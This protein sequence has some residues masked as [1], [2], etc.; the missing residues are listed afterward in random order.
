ML[1][2]FL[3][4]KKN[5]HSQQYM[6]STNS[7]MFN[8]NN[9][10][11]ISPYVLG[12]TGYGFL[13]MLRFWNWIHSVVRLFALFIQYYFCLFGAITNRDERTNKK[14][15]RERQMDIHLIGLDSSYCQYI[16]DV[17]RERTRVRKFPAEILNSKYSRRALYILVLY[18]YSNM[19]IGIQ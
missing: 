1:F 14:R 16:A 7:K 8:N 17:M 11:V 10:S 19:Q 3:K 9:N 15:D 2:S 5:I 12:W 4:K 6:R 13:F 18:V